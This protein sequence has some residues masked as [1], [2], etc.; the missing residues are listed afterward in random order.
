MGK[1][2]L[3]QS[4]DDSKFYQ[5]FNQDEFKPYKEGEKEKTLIQFIK[6]TDQGIER[7]DDY[8]GKKVVGD[9]PQSLFGVFSALHK[10]D[11]K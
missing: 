6:T 1:L 3:I 10:V 4:D 11:K 9:D 7:L 8:F 2:K 5:S